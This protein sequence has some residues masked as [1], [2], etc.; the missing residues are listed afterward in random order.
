MLKHISLP[1]GH[2][3]RAIILYVMHTAVILQKNTS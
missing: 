1:C 2:E 3:L